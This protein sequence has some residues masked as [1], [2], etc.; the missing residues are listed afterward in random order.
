MCVCSRWSQERKP[1]RGIVCREQAHRKSSGYQPIG[2]KSSSL[3]KINCLSCF[4]LVSLRAGTSVEPGVGLP[5]IF[6]E[7]V[8]WPRRKPLRRQLLPRR[9]LLR[10]LSRRP[11]RRRSKFLLLLNGNN[12]TGL[13][14]GSP[15]FLRWVFFSEL[16]SRG[17]L[18]SGPSSYR[19]LFL[20]SP[21]LATWVR[22]GA[23]PPREHACEVQRRKSGPIAATSSPQ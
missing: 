5:L 3:G 7:D 21:P 14:P 6:T 16:Y 9:R 20:Q 23:C 10:R 15:I 22:A 19:A 2:T 18:L 13:P 11:L 17:P 1:F 4:G 8:L 12:E